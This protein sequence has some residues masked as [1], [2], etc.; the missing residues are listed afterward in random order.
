MVV[1]DNGSPPLSST[2]SFVVNVVDSGPPT[3]VAKAKVNTRRGLTITL[4]FSQPLDPSTVG[5][6]NDFILVP[7]GKKP[8]RSPLASSIPMAVSYDA[9]TH[10]VTLAA[11]SR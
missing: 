2:S 5:D 8:K 11:Q 7:A 10:T 1:T 4:R 3:T 6:L 9:S